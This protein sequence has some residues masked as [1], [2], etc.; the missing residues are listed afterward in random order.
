MVQ[1][2]SIH[3]KQIVTDYDDVAPQAAA[4]RLPRRVAAV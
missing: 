1:E 4:D 2:I 3:V